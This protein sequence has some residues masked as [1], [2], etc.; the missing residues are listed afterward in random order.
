MF[1]NTQFHPGILTSILHAYVPNTVHQSSVIKPGQLIF[2][3]KILSMPRVLFDSGAL[4]SNYIDETFVDSHPQQFTPI[5]TFTD[6]TV[7]LGDNQTTIPLTR[8]VRVTA[9]FTD[10]DNKCHTAEI[11][12]SVLNMP[13][14]QMIIGL[15]SILFTF[16]DFFVD[17]LN[18]ARLNLKIK[19]RNTP[20]T[21]RNI[22]LYHDCRHPWTTPPYPEAIEDIQTPEPCSFTG[23]LAFLNSTHTESVLEYHSQFLKH[24]APEFLAAVA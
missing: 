19:Q 8:T 6:H 12:C 4:Q 14:T 16:Y 2:H 18:H 24:I 3:N 20:D 7:R 13:G 22:N 23:P 5:T 1:P 9:S 17:L 15:P 10:F 11:D 21:M